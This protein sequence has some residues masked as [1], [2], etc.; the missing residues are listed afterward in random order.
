MFLF[1]T[2]ENIATNSLLSKTLCKLRMYPSAWPQ[3]IFVEGG[4]G[5]LTHP[6]K[7]DRPPNEN[8]NYGKR[9][10]FTG[11]QPKVK[12]IKVVLVHSVIHNSKVT[13]ICS[14][15][16][17]HTVQV[18]IYSVRVSSIYLIHSNHTTEAI[19]RPAG[20]FR[21]ALTR[22]LEFAR[23]VVHEPRDEGKCMGGDGGHKTMHW[24]NGTVF[25]QR[26]LEK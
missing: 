14:T 8:D 9:H 20:V 18:N 15:P 23:V 26:V 21:G 3:D 1:L 10:F 13:G 7:M 25:F 22:E 16:C 19:R 17:D 5:S 24:A 4:K 12:N 11:Y 2:V 6:L